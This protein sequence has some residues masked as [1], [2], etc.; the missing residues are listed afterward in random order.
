[1]SAGRFCVLT[2]LLAGIALIVVHL[3]AEQTRC[4]G[5]VLRLESQWIQTRRQWWALQ[6]RAARLQAPRRL[7]DR[8]EVVQKELVVPMPDSVVRNRVR[9]TSDRTP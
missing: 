4:A 9:L 2:A 5:R 1:M 6:T 3:R 8:L 7:R